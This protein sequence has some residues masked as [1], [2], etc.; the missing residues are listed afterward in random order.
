M[1]LPWPSPTKTYHNDTYPA[2]DPTLPHLSTKGKN[3]VITGGGSGI[4]PV[5]ATNFAKSGATS[6]SLLGRTEKTLLETK[7][8]IESSYPATK[9]SIYVTDIVN[10]AALVEA[11]KNIKATHGNVDVLIANAGYLS[12]IQPIAKAEN[13]FDDWWNGYEV[14]VKGN[15]NLVTAFLL[16][17]A[18]N[19][20][21]VN[22]ST[23]ITHFLNGPGFSAYHTSKL[24]ASKFFDYVHHEYPDFFVVNV[25]PGVLETAMDVKTKAAGVIFPYDKVELPGTF[26]VWVVSDEAKFL[27]G[28]M[29]WAHW[30]V[31]ELKSMKK[32]IEGTDKF[33]FGLLGWA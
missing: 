31:D 22:I 15:F 8:K 14:N 2:I 24:A 32:E 9:V 28:K 33:T 27:N 19:A 4:G 3:I 16:V 23:A 21:V 25:H 5:I 6:I 7:S 29:I 30:D 26:L 18:K 20:A 12:N 1:A 13:D 17:A 10:K 11:F